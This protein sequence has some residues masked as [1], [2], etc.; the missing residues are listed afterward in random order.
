MV[1]I[2]ENSLLSTVQC[3]ANAHYAYLDALVVHEPAI[4]L[5]STR[6]LRLAFLAFQIMLPSFAPP[7]GVKA[8][9]QDSNFTPAIPARRDNDVVTVKG[10]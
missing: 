6:V 1:A 10:V 2:N 3:I 5:P 7:L 4:H 9:P 8:V